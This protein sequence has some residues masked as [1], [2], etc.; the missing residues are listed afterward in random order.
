[1]TNERPRASL[2]GGPEKG[3]NAKRRKWNLQSECLM[4]VGMDVKFPEDGY[5]DGSDEEYLVF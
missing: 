2:Q 1:M 5:G 3:K 4:K